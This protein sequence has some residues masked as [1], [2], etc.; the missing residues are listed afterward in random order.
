[1]FIRSKAESWQITKS[2]VVPWDKLR[3]PVVPESN[4]RQYHSK[5][6]NFKFEAADLKLTLKQIRPPATGM[7]LPR[8]LVIKREPSFDGTLK[9][10]LNPGG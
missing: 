10:F 8:C 3:A 9:Q 6:S 1:M 4:L 7:S 5:I 2:W